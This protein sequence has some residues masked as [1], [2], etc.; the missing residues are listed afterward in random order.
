MIEQFLAA[1]AGTVIESFINGCIRAWD[2][3]RDDNA[4][5]E[6]GAMREKAKQLEAANEAKAAM[7]VETD[8]E[9]PSSEIK[10]R[11]KKGTF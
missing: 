2:E 7:D 8:R 10:E 11:L 1:F 5:E 9:R 3:W 6:L 4:R